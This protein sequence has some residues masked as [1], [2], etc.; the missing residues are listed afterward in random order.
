[1][2]S[3]PGVILV[4][5]RKKIKETL[6]NP[7]FYIIITFGYVIVYIIASG[8]TDIIRSDGINPEQNPL[9]EILF[10][11][12]TGTSGASFLERLFAEGPFTLALSL[13][14]IPLLLYLLFSSLFK[15]G[16]EK[17]TGALE[18]VVCGPVGVH[19]YILG[20]FL[21]NLFFLIAYLLSITLLSALG[22]IITNTVLGTV[23]FTSMIMLFILSLALFSLCIFCS[24]I[25]RYSFAS[26]A[27]FVV[28]S[29]FFTV[30]H[31]GTLASVQGNVQDIWQA[32]TG[33]VQFVSPLYYYMNG[34]AAIDYGDIAGYVINILIL[35][36]ISAIL[37]GSGY[38][39][40]RKKGIAL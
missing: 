36:L 1:M 28:I 31:F 12:L 9:F 34:L 38:I 39:I 25:S 30:V 14:L 13:S 11:F 5:T 32:I 23:F 37:T 4:I 17:T 24:V 40:S 19:F 3:I 6:L 15:L 8:F 33:I 27:F 7:I 2:N 21:R 16:Y 29:G 26:L 18:L 22:A 10:S 35:V 20:S